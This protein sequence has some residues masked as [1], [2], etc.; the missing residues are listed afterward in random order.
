MNNRYLLLRN[1]DV[2][3]SNDDLNLS[4]YPLSKKGYEQSLG[5]I[6][7]LSKENIDTVFS[8]PHRRAIET[9][10]PYCEKEELTITL[11]NRLEEPQL[12]DLNKDEISN[13]FKQCWEK[14][15][16][17][18]NGVESSFSYIERFQFF[19]DELEETFIGKSFLICIHSSLIGLYLKKQGYTFQDF[20]KMDS[21]SLFVMNK[22]EMFENKRLNLVITNS[23]ERIRIIRSY[24]RFRRVLC[25]Y[26]LY[27]F[28]SIPEAKST[29][30]FNN[31]KMLPSHVVHRAKTLLYSDI[32]SLFDSSQLAT[33]I[34]RD[35]AKY[36]FKD[37]ANFI[38]YNL[39]VCLYERDSIK[40]CQVRH[41]IGF[42]Y[43]LKFKSLFS[44]SNS[45]HEINIQDTELLLRAIGL[46]FKGISIEEPVRYGHLGDLYEESY[47]HHQYLFINELKT[48]C[49]D[50][51]L[52]E[53]E[54]T[55]FENFL[56]KLK[57][58]FDY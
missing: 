4:E 22:S 24:E 21:P 29:V 3:S 25:T 16:Y 28:S 53:A 43:G 11:D 20:L 5:L 17:E 46:L 49:Y 38:L 47:L 45:Y 48:F 9:V 8:S 57:V 31:H 50:L 54:Y 14:P 51:P 36:Q 19:I 44:G 56:N 10:S 52:G 1:A 35:L 13:F 37:S 40:Y 2:D 23:E 15:K 39:I 33:N 30:D 27:R 6:K 55:K 58:E 26:Q 12:G 32:Y 42:H 7:E 18:V 34:K 41:N